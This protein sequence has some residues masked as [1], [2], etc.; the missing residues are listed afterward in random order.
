MKTTQPSPTPSPSRQA[1]GRNPVQ[2]PPDLVSKK[3]KRQRP[4]LKLATSSVFPKPLD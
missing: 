1:F 4:S 3:P 2:T